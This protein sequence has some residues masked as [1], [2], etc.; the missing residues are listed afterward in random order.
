MI[1]NMKKF[2]DGLQEEIQTL[3]EEIIKIKADNETEIEEMI[4]EKKKMVEKFNIKEVCIIKF[5]L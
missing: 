3:K 2:Q 1:K 5:N 4:K